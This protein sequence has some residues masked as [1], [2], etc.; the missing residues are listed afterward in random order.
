VK[1]LLGTA[2]QLALF[3]TRNVVVPQGTFVRESV[4]WWLGVNLTSTVDEVGLEQVGSTPRKPVRRG[5]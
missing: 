5:E 3:V 4:S 1:E 2:A